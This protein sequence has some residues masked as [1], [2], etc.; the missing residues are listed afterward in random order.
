MTLTDSDYNFFGRR[1]CL[2]VLNK[3]V[4]GLKDGYRQ[5]LALLGSRH[6]GKTALI[7]RFISDFDDKDV[8]ILYLDLESR[9]FN[10]FVQ[11]FSKGLLYHFLKN[12]SLPLQ[13]D[14]K[15]LCE[16]CRLSI[17]LI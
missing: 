5:N 4:R 11:Q 17:P 2:D 7:K 16:S 6:V 8:I 10:Y 12:Q 9:D 13:E 14:I 3:R 1:Q 15:L